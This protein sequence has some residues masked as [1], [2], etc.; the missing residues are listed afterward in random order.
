M[1]RG[2]SSRKTRLSRSRKIRKQNDQCR[3]AGIRKTRIS[4]KKRVTIFKK[5]VQKPSPAPKGTHASSLRGPHKAQTKDSRQGLS[6]R[7]HRGRD[8]PP[9]R[10]RNQ[11]YIRRICSSTGTRQQFFPKP[12]MKVPRSKP[13][14][15]PSPAS[16]W[17]ENALASV[18][19]HAVSCT[20]F[21][22]KLRGVASPQ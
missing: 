19:S 15:S 13:L 7:S 3:R 12:A 20:L 6:L 16:E 2:P 5:I 14:R 18:S 21:L 22:K 8:R 9:Q 17:N 1:G 10:T 11:N 4:T